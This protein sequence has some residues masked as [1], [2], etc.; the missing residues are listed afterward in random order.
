MGRIVCGNNL[1][2]FT[3]QSPTYATEQEAELFW[4]TAFIRIT[5]VFLWLDVTFLSR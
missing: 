1:Y 2:K 4:D 3:V 5:S